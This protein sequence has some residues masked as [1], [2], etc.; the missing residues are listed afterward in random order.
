M[1][2][3]T[4]RAAIKGSR[5]SVALATPADGA[6][7]IAGTIGRVCTQGSRSRAS[8]PNN[9]SRGRDQQACGGRHCEECT[10]IAR[11]DEAQGNQHPEL[12]LMTSAPRMAPARPGR[13]MHEQQTA[14]IA[15]LPSNSVLAGES[16]VG[17]CGTE[18]D[19]CACGLVKPR[20]A[21]PAIAVPPCPPCTGQKSGSSGSKDSGTGKQKDLAADRA[22]PGEESPHQTWNA[23]RH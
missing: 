12:W 5:S 1:L 8:T 14:E 18:Q 15:M 23:T 3:S 13:S 7:S 11:R 10:P 9:S 20:R 17:E 4:D 16:I 19:R 21:A 2:A 22:I 6:S